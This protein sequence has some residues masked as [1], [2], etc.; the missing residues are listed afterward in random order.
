MKRNMRK[1][2]EKIWALR[3]L[4]VV[5]CMVTILF[6]VSFVSHADEKGNITGSDVNMRQTASTTATVLEVLNN[7][8]LVDVLAET[9]GDDGNKWY[10]IT[11]AAGNTGYVRADFVK[12]AT[13]TVPVTDTEDKTAYILGNS[14]NIRQDASTSSGRVA[15]AAGGSKITIIGEA[16][17]ADGYKW[18]QVSFDANGTTMTGFIRSDLITFQEPTQAPEITEIEGEMGEGSEPESTSSETPEEP[19]EVP[20]EVPSESDTPKIPVEAS[21]DDLD[22]MEPD[23]AV[24]ILPAGFEQT[25]LT[26]GEEVFTVWGKDNFYIMYA[27][28]K[29]G[30]PRYYLYDSANKGYVEY[31]GLLSAQDVATPQMEEGLNFKLISIIC[32]AV[33]VILIIVIFILGYKLSNAGFRDDDDDD[34]DNDDDDVYVDDDDD[35]YVDLS[36]DDD[37][38]VQVDLEETEVPEEIAIEQPLYEAPVSEAVYEPAVEQE[39][40]YDSYV[41]LMP[42]AQAVDEAAY[43]MVSEPVYAENMEAL[44]GYDA[45]AY[46]MPV[47]EE[48]Y[49]ESGDALAGYVAAGEMLYNEESSEEEEESFGFEEEEEA[50]EPQKSRKDK[51][52]KK[53]KKEKKSFSQRFL[54]YFTVEV[55]EDEDDDEEDDDDDVTVNTADDDSDDDDDLN[56]IDI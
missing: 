13:V 4:L 18:Y 12:K 31:T 7:N 56:F 55:D 54:D 42:E 38:D 3:G 51:K 49:V 30:E 26:L 43:S 32:I 39:L 34:D 44:S 5:F 1:M 27:S 24:E 11:S 41:E 46:E 45:S 37:I 2:A 21:M 48:A 22:I 29:G 17:G 8:A 6:G 33:I 53:A 36:D 20:S 50:E 16:T 19:S 28:A 15:N 14:A 47:T 23:S 35:E 52:A 25:E 10:K 9:T 40:M